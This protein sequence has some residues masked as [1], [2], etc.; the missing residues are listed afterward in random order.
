[1]ASATARA[2]VASGLGEPTYLIT[3]WFSDHG[4]RG[5]D[6]IAAAELIER[7]RRGRDL[8]AAATARSVATSA[9]AARTLALGDEHVHPKDIEFATR[10]D[11][12]DFAME[13]TRF[14]DRLRIFHLTQ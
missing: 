4:A 3:G 13:V 14:G 1:M 11:A 8:D 2:V 5:D 10:I 7:A 12:F 9:E 6:D